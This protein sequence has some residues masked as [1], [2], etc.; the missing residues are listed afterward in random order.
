MVKAKSKK[1]IT[2]TKMKACP[3]PDHMGKK[4]PATSEYW[5]K[6]G[7]PD[8]L[9]GYCKQWR[10]KSQ[11]AANKAARKAAR[12]A[13]KKAAQKKARR[14]QQNAGSTNRPKTIKAVVKQTKLQRAIDKS[15]NSSEKENPIVKAMKIVA[16]TVF[17]KSC[18]DL[19]TPEDFQ[20]NG[21]GGF[22]QPCK[23]CI[24]K[25]RAEQKKEVDRDVN[26]EYKEIAP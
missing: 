23:S 16:S 2:K 1:K 21:K 26:P 7:N 20:S 12:R 3:C 10:N 9:Q 14:N 19:C 25:K 5:H 17:C 4:L 15:I 11:N 18:N 13:G 8:G 24:A 6:G 22:R